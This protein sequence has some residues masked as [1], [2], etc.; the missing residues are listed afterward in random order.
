[1]A[2]RG[3]SGGKRWVDYVTGRPGVVYVLVNPAFTTG[4]IKIGASTR[5]GV[6]R[7]QEL[8]EQAR[9]STPAE[10]RCVHEVRTSD[11][12]TAER[13]AHRWLADFRRG[14]WGQEYFDADLT[15]VRDLV[16]RACRLVDDIGAH[17]A[18]RALCPI[19]FDPLEWT[20][21]PAPLATAASEP[22]EG[23]APA[24]TTLPFVTLWVV[25]LAVVVAWEFVARRALAG[26]L[27][28]HARGVL[29]CAVGL[30]ALYAM[31]WIRHARARRR[32]L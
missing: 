22:A 12:G 27:V 29:V 1:M 6:V 28:L 5:S 11:C 25:C 19:S 2:A 21:S 14:G 16:T 8:N 9:T 31:V 30:S 10:F 23:W 3:K 7:A 32:G 4:L 18:S 26:F 20:G 15:L 13:L 24:D 17:A